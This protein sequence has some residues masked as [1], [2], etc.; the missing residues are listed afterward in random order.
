MQPHPVGKA[1]N[2]SSGIIRR[3]VEAVWLVGT[4]VRAIR[5]EAAMRTGKGGRGEEAPDRSAWKRLPTGRRD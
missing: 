5:I 3:Q 1:A 2:N 4:D